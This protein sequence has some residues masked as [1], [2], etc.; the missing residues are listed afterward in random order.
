MGGRL[1]MLGSFLLGL[2]VA[3]LWFL[4]GH[5]ER[6]EPVVLAEKLPDISPTHPSETTELVPSVVEMPRVALPVSEIVK[7]ATAIRP[8]EPRLLH[9][10]SSFEESLFRNDPDFTASEAN[11]SAKYRDLTAQQLKIAY[12]ASK[13]RYWAEG[14]RIVKERMEAGLFEQRVLGPDENVPIS[15][16]RDGSAVFFGFHFEP[17]LDGTTLAKT[18]VVPYEENPEFRSLACEQHWIHD[19]LHRLGACNC[20]K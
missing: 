2:I 14:Q 10:I 18:T 7:E 15:P 16:S 9:T 5:V 13:D 4:I 3:S 12:E 20:N 8:E 11:L 19:Q 17:G 6:V 1:G